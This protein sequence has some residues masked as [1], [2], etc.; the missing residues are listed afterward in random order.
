M[1]L[2]VGE[3]LVAEIARP[4]G[5]ASAFPRPLARTVNATG[6]RHAFGAIRS[7]P[8]YAASARTRSFAAALFPAASLRAYR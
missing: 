1:L 3:F 4:A 5:L 2:A 7:R 8:A 6:I